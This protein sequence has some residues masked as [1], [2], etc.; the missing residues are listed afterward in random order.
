MVKHAV[1]V[2]EP[3]MQNSIRTRKELAA[4]RL[5]EEVYLMVMTSPLAPRARACARRAGLGDLE[6]RYGVLQFVRNLAL[7]RWRRPA[8]HEA[9]ASA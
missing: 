6:L 8:G 3:A 7:D 5:G 4:E 9:K 2:G 1:P